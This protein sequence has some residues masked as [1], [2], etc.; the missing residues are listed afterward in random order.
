MI[1]FTRRDYNLTE[2]CAP[3]VRKFRPYQIRLYHV[4]GMMQADRPPAHVVCD[5]PVIA[6]RLRTLLVST[7]TMGQRWLS[8]SLYDDLRVR[9]GLRRD[10]RGH[11]DFCRKV[12]TAIIHSVEDRIIAESDFVVEFPQGISA[13]A[14]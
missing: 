7:S 11:V 13:I 4:Y 6:A 1:T 8:V 2:I 12:L 10:L 14:D 9:I 5:S 3:L